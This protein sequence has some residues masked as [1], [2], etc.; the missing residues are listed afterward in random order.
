MIRRW[1][2]NGHRSQPESPGPHH[3]PLNGQRSDCPAQDPDRRESPL[4][5]NGH[6]ELLRNSDLDHSPLNG[7]RSP[8]PRRD[9]SS[10]RDTLA[11]PRRSRAKPVG[12]QATGFPAPTR[13]SPLNGNTSTARSTTGTPH[14]PRC[15]H[16]PTPRGQRHRFRPGQR[17][18]TMTTT[19][20]AAASSNEMS[21]R[22]NGRF[23]HGVFRSSEM[24]PAPVKISVSAHSPSSSSYSQP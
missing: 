17:V 23:R 14:Q 12:T 10:S 8:R 11:Y 4:N 6:P 9:T 20:A 5:G 22:G 24:V 15:C 2:A 3:S 21:P 1:T 16:Q 7:H 19:D 18:R 13:H